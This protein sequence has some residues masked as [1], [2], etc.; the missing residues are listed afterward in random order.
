[1]VD[2]HYESKFYLWIIEAFP[3]YN[4]KATDFDLLIAHD[5]QL[6]DS[7]EELEIHNYLISK[8]INGIKIKREGKRFINK[9]EKEVYIPDWI[10]IKGDQ[11]FIIEYFGLYGSSRYPSYT[12]KTKRKITFFNSICDYTFIPIMP[13]DFRNKGFIYID[14]LLEGNGLLS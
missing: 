3:E 8:L 5:G 11:K 14:K 13:N 10:I 6:C 12:E 9:D 2:R 7:K 4:F 1:M